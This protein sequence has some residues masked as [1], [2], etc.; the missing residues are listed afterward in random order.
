MFGA[1]VEKVRFKCSAA[2]QLHIGESSVGGGGGGQLP[3]TRG[4]RRKLSGKGK[5]RLNKEIHRKGFALGTEA[6]SA[7]RIA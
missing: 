7:R 4:G 2:T 3:R 1:G 6:T 5:N